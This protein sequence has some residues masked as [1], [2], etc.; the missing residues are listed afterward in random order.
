[1]AAIHFWCG[2]EFE[3]TAQG[4]YCKCV[5]SV[6]SRY[7]GGV[8]RSEYVGGFKESECFD[9]KGDFIG[10]GIDFFYLYCCYFCDGYD[11]YEEYS[12]YRYY[13][14]ARC[15]KSSDSGLIVDQCMAVFYLDGCI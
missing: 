15:N 12:V 4:D 8:C 5:W 10:D 1:M 11:C 6:F 3:S 2:G 13:C 7:S 9:T 14:H